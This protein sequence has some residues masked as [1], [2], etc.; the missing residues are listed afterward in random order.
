MLAIDVRSTP[1]S[2]RMAGHLP[3]SSSVTGVRFSAAARMITRPMP[4]LPV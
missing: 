3:P 2:V 1:S 4:G